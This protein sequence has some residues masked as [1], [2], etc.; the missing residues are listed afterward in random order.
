MKTKKTFQFVVVVALLITLPLVT[1]MLARSGFE[2]RISALEDDT[3]RHVT[4]TDIRGDSFKVSW[5][6]ER[7]V[8]G[9]I[10]FTTG[11]RFVENDRTSNHSI[12]IP[13]L[14]S[15]TEYTFK[16]LSGSKEFKAENDKNYSVTTGSD[17]N[18][19]SPFLIYGQVF[20]PDGYTVQQG[21]IVILQL[22][23][24]SVKSQLVSTTINEAGGYQI[25]IAGMLS[26]N[27]ARL[28]PYKTKSTA[29]VTVYYSHEEKQVIKR[30]AVDLSTNRQ[31]PPVYL[32]DVNIDIIPAID[33]T[34]E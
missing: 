4:I 21:G 26:N 23:N 33:G 29:I 18:A 5:I 17:T 20:S 15:N 8:I 9:G 3:P 11:E 32:G 22:E 6:T 16:M 24:A 34:K 10:L 13:G 1:G 27:L 19:E 28:Y 7:P 14:L 25:D 30:F 2:L 12:A 31:I